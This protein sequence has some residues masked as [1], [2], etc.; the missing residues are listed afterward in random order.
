MVAPG[1]ERSSVFVGSVEL[2]IKSNLL[3]QEAVLHKLVHQGEHHGVGRSLHGGGGAR[4]EGHDHT[5]GQEEEEHGGRNE[6]PHCF[7]LLCEN[8][9]KDHQELVIQNVHKHEHRIDEHHLP[10]EGFDVVF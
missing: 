4:G 7:V 3:L 2:K 5:R 6:V 10:A 1:S 8:L 9:P